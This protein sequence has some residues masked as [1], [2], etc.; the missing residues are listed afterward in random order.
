[1]GRIP[2]EL[3][4]QI[5]DRVDLVDLVGRF[6]SLKRSGRSH[7]GLCPFHSEKTPSFNVNPDRQAFY[8]FGCQEGGNAITFLMKIENLTFPEAARTLAR[9]C[10]IEIPETGGGEPG[11]SER[12]RAANELAH[13]HYRN[14]LSSTDNPAEAYLASRGLDAATIARFEIGYAPD[15]WDFITRALQERGIPADIGERAG[16]LARRDSGGHYDRLRGRVIFPIRDVRGRVMGFGGRALRSDQEPKYLN[17]PESPIF[18]KRES[19]YGFPHALEPIRRTGRAVVVEGYFDLIALHRA[20]VEGV[21]ATCGTALT[22]DHARGLRQRSRQ[23]VLLFDGDE[24]GQRAMERSLEILLPEDLRVRAALLPPGEDPDSFLA[25][26]GA[27][28]LCRLVAEAPSALDAVIDR[29]G[30]GGCN[31]PW[32]K[33]DA[34]A[35]VARLLA[36]VPGTVERHEFCVRL[37]FT[38]R[39]EVQHV[40]DAVRA[41]ARGQD[42]AG[43][44]PVEVRRAG[45]EERILNQLARSLVEHPHLTAGVVRDE[46]L[47]LAPACPATEVVAALIDSAGAGRRFVLDE[48]AE[49]LGPEAC[50]LLH[51]LAAADDV[52]EEAAAQRTL[53]DTLRRLR[54]DR[55]RRES[56]EITRRMRASNSDAYALLREK[57]EQR[58]RAA[59][60][61]TDRPP[62]GSQ[63]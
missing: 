24:A 57:E 20:G 18:R 50:S 21:V 37:A 33:A 26:E 10:G 32:E 2:D 59:R 35:A 27:E 34:V 6:V 13:S 56:Q 41:A 31:T 4:D 1:M 17:T 22:P 53:E 58:R 63:S 15:G 9:E 44:I 60:E 12:L 51:S 54:K 52:Q 8:C 14:A 46:F 11:L 40:E 61:F 16:L 19:F 47:A 48:V 36:L 30:A 42:A 38:T 39:T 45:P 49:R 28:A 62:A 43:A 29:A 55:T 3:I 23:V 5:R 25:R 7:K